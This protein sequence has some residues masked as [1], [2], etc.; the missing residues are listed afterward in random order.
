MAASCPFRFLVSAGTV[1]DYLVRVVDK[2]RPFRESPGTQRRSR[3]GRDG[4]SRLCALVGQNLV[5]ADEA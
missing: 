3:T 2:K 4:S 5:R 1:M